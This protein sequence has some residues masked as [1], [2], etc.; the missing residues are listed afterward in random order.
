MSIKLFNDMLNENLSY[1]LLKP[2]IE[3]KS[4]LWKN[5]EHKEDW[6]GDLIVPFQAGRASS[7]KAGG[8]V[9]IADITSQKL[10]RGSIADSSRPEINMA[11]V[12]HHKDIFN[13]EGKVKAKSFLGTFLP[14]QISDATDFFAKT[15]N[16]TFLN[17]KH[18]DK[19]AD[20]TNLASSKI[21][22]NRPERFELDMKVILDPT[23]ANVTGWVK[24]ININTGELLIVTAKG[25]STG[26][27]LTGVAVGELIYQEGFA[28]SSVSNLKDI[29]LPVAAGGASTVYGQTKT[30]S[31]YTQALAIDGSGMSTSNIFEKIFDAYSKYRQLAKVGAGELWCSFKHLGTMMKKLEQDKGAYKMVPGS[32]KVSQYGFTTIEIFG[33]GGSLK[34]VAMQEM[35]NDFMTFVS[36]DAMK[37]HS[38]GGI[39]KHKDPNG[40]AF[41]TVRDENDNYKYVVDLMYEGTIVVSKPYKCAIIYGITY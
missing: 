26:A 9:A 35:D 23:G 27:T 17:A 40:N 30:A 1:D 29:L 36:M 39:R 3:E 16:H 7:V 8:L 21:G 11:L 5:I 18:L 34:V 32:M 14:E 31:P 22:V 12:F 33:P 20:V 13:H 28:T 15:L 10:V 19:V 24:E 4:Y 38:N 25:G 37:I 41:Y 2:E 6:T